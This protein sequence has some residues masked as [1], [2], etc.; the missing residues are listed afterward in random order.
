M[1]QSFGEV[2][3]EQ[4]R[5]VRKKRIKFIII[6]L[7]GAL[8]LVVI[9]AA[10]MYG[11]MRRESQ[12]TAGEAEVADTQHASS[13]TGEELEEQ[14]ALAN[15]AGGAA[16]LAS[17]KEELVKGES[18]VEVFR[19]IYKEDLV[20]ASNGS[21]HFIPIQENLKK[22]A[23]L[24]ENLRVLESGEYQYVENGNVTSYKGIDVSKFQ[25][26]IDWEAAAA[27]GVQFAFIRVGNRGY[28]SGKIVDDESFT[29][30]MEGAIHAGIKVGV[31]FYTQAV[32]EAE[33]LEEVAYVL[34]K[35][36]PY[37]IDCPVVYDVEKVM[38]DE[39]RMNELSAEERTHLTKLFCDS[40]EEAGYQSM[41]YMN[42]EMAAM[43]LN[44]EELEAYEKWFAYYNP[45][46]YFPYEYQVW[47]YTEKGRVA[48]IEGEVDLNISFRPLWK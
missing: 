5:Q 16:L 12:S 14:L 1:R 30:N 47:Q 35:I 32:N 24:T 48:G 7:L 43:M 6:G 9:T 21:Y 10:V 19:H 45:E 41:I 38:G 33:L 8:L 20:L 13:Y 15:A 36:E 39:G 40:I 25:G 42:L 34:E 3:F 31:Y 11:L 29:K 18:A 2:L 22:N 23:Y 17:M 27:D 44:L 37:Q 46:F 26:T 4:E 28:G